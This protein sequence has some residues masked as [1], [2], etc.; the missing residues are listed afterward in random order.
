VAIN[1]TLAPKG[2]WF[3][4][5]NSLLDIL[6][7]ADG[8]VRKMGTVKASRL[9]EGITFSPDG[10]Y[11]YVGNFIDSDVQIYKVDGEQVRDTGKVLKLP[12]H[13]A[14]MRGSIP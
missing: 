13:P 6:S 10:E 8:H 2:A 5:E 1:G 14:S 3:A 12:G 4:T 9:A 7:W 11:L